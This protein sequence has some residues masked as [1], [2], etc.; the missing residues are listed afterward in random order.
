MSILPKLLAASLV[1]SSACALDGQTPLGGDGADELGDV[2]TVV[3]GSQYNRS[4]GDDDGSPA[5]ALLVITGEPAEQI[6]ADMTE[7]THDEAIPDLEQ[8][9][10]PIALDQTEGRIGRHITCRRNPQVTLDEKGKLVWE[11][12]ADGKVVYETQC[13]AEY[14]AFRN[15]ELKANPTP[16][17]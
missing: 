3:G 15:G 7:A 2:V 11:R 5:F 17:G 16:G 9:T 8:R 14:A 10:P 4:T 13:F 1:L 12:D 6:F